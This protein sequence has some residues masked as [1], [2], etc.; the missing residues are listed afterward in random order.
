MLA[1]VALLT[2][3]PALS[4]NAQ[5]PENLSR[6]S[7]F[8]VSAIQSRPQ[9]DLARNIGFGYGIN[10][11]Y[12]FRLD[13][14]GIFSLRADIGVVDYGNESKRSALSETIG[15]RVQVTVRTTNLIIPI[16]VGPQLTWPKGVFRPYVNAGVGGQGFLTETSVDGD[17]GQT[18]FASTTNHSDFAASWSVGGGVYAPVIAG[19][20]SVQIDLGVQYFN[21]SRARYLA[22]G[23][24]EDLPGGHIRINRMESATHLIVLRFGARLG[25]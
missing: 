24:I 17:G 13:N 20:R 19:K 23:S 16:A 25:L 6:R 5:S 3:L 14:T 9:G 21:G 4:S 11:A 2:A 7:S 18:S 22:P 1:S 15:D 8:S 10:G 12:E